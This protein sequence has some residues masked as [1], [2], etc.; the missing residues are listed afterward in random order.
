MATSRRPTTYLTTEELQQLAAAKFE[1]AA[2][3]A[4]GPDQQK[5]LISANGLRH[6]A[7]VR[8]WLASASRS[9]K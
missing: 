3:L 5:L 2:A 8:S 4:P 9:P 7:E 1:E 6:A